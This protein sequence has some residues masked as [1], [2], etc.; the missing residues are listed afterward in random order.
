MSYRVPSLA[1]RF[2]FRVS[3][4]VATADP[5]QKYLNPLNHA[6][7]TLIVTTPTVGASI[8]LTIQASND[9][10]NPD[11][12]TRGY[13]EI[14]TA[15]YDA[16]IIITSTDPAIIIVDTPVVFASFRFTF[17]SDIAATW[18]GKGMVG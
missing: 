17:D 14:T 6:F 13:E 3:E 7:W 4:D 5:V 11:V 15:F 8:E 9:A 16:P 10:E 2:A 12:E 1:N 18:V